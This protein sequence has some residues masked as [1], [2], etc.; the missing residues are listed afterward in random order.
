MGVD[1]LAVLALRFSHPAFAASDLFIGAGFTA[2]TCPAHRNAAM[3][4]FSSAVRVAAVAV[5]PFLPSRTAEGS[6]MVLAF[7][8]ELRRLTALGAQLHF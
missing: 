6:F 2:L 4:A 1:A 5:P 3:R 7:V 8:C